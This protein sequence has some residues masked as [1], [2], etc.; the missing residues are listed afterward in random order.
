MFD[1]L[2]RQAT[3]ERPER[4]LL[5]LR[6][7][8]EIRLSIQNHLEIFRSMSN[9]GSQKLAQAEINYEVRRE[10]RGNGGKGEK[11]NI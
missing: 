9:F 5:L 4:G 7:R 2:I 1:E 10:S 3:L 11:N 8:D 6:V